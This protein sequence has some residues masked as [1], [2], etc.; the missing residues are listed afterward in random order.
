VRGEDRHRLLQ[1][2]RARPSCL[3]VS[4]FGEVL[5]YTDTRDEMTGAA[6][7]AELRDYLAVQ[8]VAGVSVG[9]VAPTIEDVFMA[10]MAGARST[11][12]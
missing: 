5:H 6:L 8:E 10:R 2:L 9:V 3:A 1:V 12:A 11:V 7:E 4:P